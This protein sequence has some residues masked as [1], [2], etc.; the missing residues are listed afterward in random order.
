M[1]KLVL[2]IDGGTES[3]RAS[4]FDLDGNQVA[5]ASAPYG[6]QYPHPSWAEQNPDDWIEV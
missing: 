3:L 2:G 1:S 5:V 4:L 6:T